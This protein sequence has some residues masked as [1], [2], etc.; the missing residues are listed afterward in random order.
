MFASYG[1]LMELL[2]KSIN[3]VLFL[4][5]IASGG[6][7]MVALIYTK[8]APTTIPNFSQTPSVSV[9]KILGETA[10]LPVVGYGTVR[11]K[12]QV[13]IVPEVGGKLI[14]SHSALA[15]GNI[16]AAGELI[17]EIDPTMYEARV[18][19]VEA[20]IRGLEAGLQRH[21]QEITNL[22][23]RIENVEQMLAIDERAYR[24][25]KQ[26][27]DDGASTQTVLDLDLQKFLRQ[28]DVVVDLRNRRAMAPHLKLETQAQLDGA[29]AKLQQATH[30]LASTKI[31]SPFEAR[32]ETV[33]AHAPQYV[34]TIISIATLTDMS[35]FE[36]SVGID[37]RELRWLSE[38]VRPES[39]ENAEAPNGAE[40]TVRWS[41]PG[42]E[43]TWRGY[44]TRFERVD[45]ATRTA[46]LVVEV[47]NLDMVA[48]LHTGSGDA[49]P[50]LSIGMHCRA[51][52]PAEPLDGALLVP[53]HAVYEHR[54]VYVFEPNSDSSDGL[55]GT[56]GRRTVPLLRSFGEYVL[57]DYAGRTG[58]DP[59]EL[60]A[61]ELVVLSPLMR[62]VVGMRITRR[63]ES[64]AF[65]PSFPIVT[66]PVRDLE[67]MERGDA[68][69]FSLLDVVRK[70]G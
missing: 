40:V 51:E 39:L 70:G 11:P 38:A 24:T 23:A 29:R 68:V 32:V 34:P 50:R 41:L 58:T 25:S 27:Y 60:Q 44:V 48:T 28:K 13:N 37:P 26:L 22:D 17:F 18:H 42:Q 35:A 33:N 1:I 67:L 46:R 36:I 3:T 30:N 66:P 2:R 14:Y 47:R 65:A 21:D 16:I 5:L 61:G 7:A 64:V 57:V 62:P 53:R 4:A 8:P 52:L 56:L 20:E 69:A 63:N 10:E 45:E 59:C 55:I 9:A 15:Q 49:R 6:L 31:V 12:N 19:Q 54:W 43:F